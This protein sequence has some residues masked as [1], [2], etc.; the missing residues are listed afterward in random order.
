MAKS[1]LNYWLEDARDTLIEI[2]TNAKNDKQIFKAM[3]ISKQTFYKWKNDS[4][5]FA[6][7]LKNA[8]EQRIKDNTENLKQLHKDMWEKARNVKEVTKLKEI[9]KGKDGVEREYTKITTVEKQGDTTLM[10]YLDKTYNVDNINYQ[11]QKTY[12]E[13]NKARTAELGAEDSDDRNLTIEIVTHE[14]T[15]RS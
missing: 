8:K 12:V 5:D 13:L 14:D 1:K 3:G 6:D 15:E 4:N 7:L 11:Q 9:I 10:I 2:I